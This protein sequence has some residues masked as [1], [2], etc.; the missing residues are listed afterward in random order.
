MTDKDIHA[1]EE[2][3][4]EYSVE[5]RDEPRKQD[6]RS[7]RNISLPYK[8]LSKYF[9]MGGPPLVFVQYF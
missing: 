3:A 1:S 4:R 7:N 5:K 9:E 8:V 2:R 6:P